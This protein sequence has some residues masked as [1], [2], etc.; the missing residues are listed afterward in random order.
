MS[1]HEHV[2]LYNDLRHPLALDIDIQNN[3]LFWSD[4]HNSQILMGSSNP[5]ENDLPTVL[6][7]HTAVVDGIAYDWIH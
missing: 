6:L 5:Q 1:T 7:E 3:K 4:T 2:E